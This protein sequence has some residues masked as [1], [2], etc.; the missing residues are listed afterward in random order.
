MK[1]RWINKRP[2]SFT[3]GGSIRIMENGVIKDS[4]N[5]D[6]Y[7]LTSLKDIIKW[8]KD[9]NKGIV[10]VCRILWRSRYLES[11]KRYSRCYDKMC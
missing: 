10:G 11:L 5:V 2:R 3:G 6:P 1:K 8:C 4:G 7:K 9:N